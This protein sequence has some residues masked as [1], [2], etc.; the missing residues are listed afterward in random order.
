LKRVSFDD[1]R[2]EK[3]DLP[4]LPTKPRRNCAAHGCPLAGSLA[5]SSHSSN[6]WCS[7]HYG[8]HSTDLP[9]VTS[10]LN[11]HRAITDLIAE[12]RRALTST[13]IHPDQLKTEWAN[14]KQR[15]SG[16][17]I[18]PHKVGEH[19]DDPR[20]WAHRVEAMLG[21]LIVEALGKRIRSAA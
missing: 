13:E 7:Y 16:F 17:A 1:S 19:M 3:G 2:D 20:A 4:S 8:V 11:Q 12:M 6:W 21:G 18:P 5:E 9:R 14:W 10:V 15:V